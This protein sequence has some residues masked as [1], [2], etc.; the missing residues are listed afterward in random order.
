MAPYL[1]V[2]HIAVRVP[3]SLRTA[4]EYYCALFDLRVSW[5]EPAPDGAPLDLP[6]EA[7]DEAEVHPEIVMLHA[8]AL[9]ISILEA[10]STAA[11]AGLIEHVGVQVTAEQLERVGARVHAQELRII[12]ER[13]GEILDFVDRYGV[14]W[15]LDTRSFA[16]PVT[17]VEEKRQ[18]A[19]SQ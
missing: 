18:R 16:N 5:R 3:D 13:P 14:E 12:N 4:E 6:W 19:R 2:T 11:G 7:L 10:S 9:R 1:D 8:G 17:I 15:E